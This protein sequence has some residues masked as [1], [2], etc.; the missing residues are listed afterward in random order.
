[1]LINEDQRVPDIPNQRIQV[2]IKCSKRS[3]ISFITYIW[4]CSKRLVVCI[5]YIWIRGKKK[6][7]GSIIK[8]LKGNLTFFDFSRILITM[9]MAAYSFF[10][11]PSFIFWYSPLILYFQLLKKKKCNSQGSFVFY[12]WY[13]K[14][15]VTYGKDE[16][17]AWP[18]GF[19]IRILVGW[20]E[21]YRVLVPK[22]QFRMELH[23]T[24]HERSWPYTQTKWTIKKIYKHRHPF[25][26]SKSSSCLSHHVSN[27]G[28]KSVLTFICLPVCRMP[29]NA[30]NK[31]FYFPPFTNN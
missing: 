19:Y 22:F 20:I 12:T 9:I 8:E 17:D 28:L 25:E 4:I 11:L 14:T 5:D 31:D 16:N 29:S 2:S 7:H 10:I 24:V 13:T 30:L 21:G 18:N 3:I 6:L 23:G 15:D 1:M 27:S 26:T